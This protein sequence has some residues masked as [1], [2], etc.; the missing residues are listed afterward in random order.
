M[1]IYLDHNATSPV[2][3]SAREAMFEAA[4]L[5]GNPSSIHGEGRAVRSRLERARDAITALVG[6]GTADGIVFTS[7]GTEADVSGIVGLGLAA[8]AAGAP[9]RV[10]VLATDHPAVHGAAAALVARGFASEVLAVDGAG[11]VDGLDL[12]RRL[13]TP[14]AVVAVAA[15][16]HETGVIT[17][18]A[19][20]AA[21]ARAAGARLHVDAVQAAGRVPL[22]AI[23]LHADTLALSAHKLG[24][25]AGVGALWIR[26]G[27]DLAPLAPGGHQERGRR[28]GTENVVGAAGF[29]AAAAAV[30][31][32]R[33]GEVAARAAR[34]ERGILAIDG[35]RIHGAGAPR[36]GNTVNAGFA[37]ALGESIVMS[38]DLDGVAV[39]TGAACTSG[40]VQP[41]PVLLAMG[42]DRAAA[43]EGVRFSLGP[44]TTDAELDRVLAILP[45]IVARVRAASR[46]I[47]G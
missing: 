21:A 41:S 40:S 24:G 33:A 31:L 46:S 35:A 14:A 3:D 39:S 1:R 6:S 32:A 23:A 26:S 10:V 15:V 22:A 20:V 44:S 2:L 16:N 30:D 5:V 42:L 19:V 13:A 47:G 25:P 8:V 17:D 9:A 28:G 29:A 18:L 34:L 43:R 7:G 36:V 4:G 11:Q 45:G 38:L 37:G 27:V 12:A